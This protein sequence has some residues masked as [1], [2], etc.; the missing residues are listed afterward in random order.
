MIDPN[1]MSE[2]ERELLE[3]VA[4]S[5]GHTLEEELVA[6][7]HSV[8]PEKDDSVSFEGTAQTAE[9]LPASEDVPAFMDSN[10]LAVEPPIEVEKPTAPEPETDELK[11]EVE[12]DFDPPPPPAAEDDEPPPGDDDDDDEEIGGTIKQ[13]CVQCGW[14]QDVQTIP[15]P[16]SKDKIGFL[17]SVLGHKVFSKKYTMSVGT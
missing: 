7:G 5:K 11:I 14:D 8:T 17:Q 1:K 13:V 15:D 9:P 16:D 10:P 4:K 6:L 12:P 2:T 3:E